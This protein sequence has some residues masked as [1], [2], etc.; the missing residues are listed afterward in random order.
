MTW[1]APEVAAAV[2][3]PHPTLPGQS[4]EDCPGQR[5][6][7]AAG[8]GCPNA[9]RPRRSGG[10]EEAAASYSVGVGV[11]IMAA[12]V[13]VV[14]AAPALRGGGGGGG[15][16]AVL[17]LLVT[18]ADAHNWLNSPR[19]RAGAASTIKPCRK[20][21]NFEQPGVQVNRGQEFMIEWMTG[22]GGTFHYFVILKAEHEERLGDISEAVINEYLADAPDDA[23]YMRDSR[24]AAR[25]QTIA[26]KYRKLHWGFPGQTA[27]GPGQGASHQAYTN[28]GKTVVNEGDGLGE[29]LERP[30]SF[31]CSTWGQHKNGCC[32]GNNHEACVRD[33]TYRK[34]PGLALYRY[35][36]APGAHDGRDP[37]GA[38]DM[39]RRV[40]YVHPKYP[41]IE[42]VR[43]LP[44]G[45]NSTDQ[46]R[47][48]SLPRLTPPPSICRSTASSRST[49]GPS[50][51]TPRASTSPAA[52]PPPPERTSSTTCGEATATAS[53]STC[54]TR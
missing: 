47:P 2:K 30:E 6:A 52:P 54:S 44:G 24:D 29:W 33:K 43:N 5:A 32:P 17:A 46:R 49:R 19:A 35:P 12:A 8:G 7:A 23:Y 25:A 13:G 50:S 16:K 22:H 31:L 45:S 1:A 42:A 21:T 51:L 11:G 26:P 27:T 53:T 36:D 18:A 34:I 40:A 37:R 39:D 3:P 9:P 15:R 20:R 38:N 4:A 10:A 14:A 48:V 41:Y 28:Q